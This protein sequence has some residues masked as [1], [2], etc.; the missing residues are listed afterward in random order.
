[1]NNARKLLQKVKEEISKEKGYK[2][3]EHCINDQ[4]NW[5]VEKVMDLVAIRLALYSLQIK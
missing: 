1:M 3:W 2:S 4:P 5:K